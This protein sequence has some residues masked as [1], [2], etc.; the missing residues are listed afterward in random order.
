MIKFFR[1][2]R[3]NFLLE[4]KTGKYLKYAIGE[5]ILVVIG[6]LIALQINNWNENRI[7]N[8]EELLILKSLKSEFVENQT[9]LTHIISKHSTYLEL[10]KELNTLISPE[11]SEITSGKL[12]TLML[13]LNALPKYSP[14]NGV[15]N[16]IITSAKISLIKNNELSTRLS[17]LNSKL[18]LYNMVALRNEKDVYEH[19][20][21]YIKDKYPFKQTLKLYTN[22]KG[23]NKDSKFNYSTN[24]LLS[25][26][27]FE[28][29]VANR[30]VDAADLLKFANDLYDFQTQI[31]NLI[32]T[33]L[34]E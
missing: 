30:L 9:L 7:N 5:I 21:P 4:G 32:E 10:L 15:I 14:N 20:I 17:S 1:N 23:I 2:I 12:D 8:R 22:Y 16:S 11:P 3:R 27:G 29:L 6:I 33:E 34:E 31:L 13:G 24:D 25:D 26:L 28:S 18:E 19:I